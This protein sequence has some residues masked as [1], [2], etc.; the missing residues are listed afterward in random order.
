MN[1]A[2][3]MLLYALARTSV[4]LAVAAIVAF[5]LLR[6]LRCRSPAVHRAAWCMVLLTGW[7]FVRATVTIPWYE[8]PPLARQMFPSPASEVLEVAPS[9]DPV[10]SAIGSDPV[11]L[12]DLPVKIDE[13]RDIAGT[14]LSWP[15][16]LAAVWL[17][18]GV[19]IV[20]W[21]SIGYL[22]FVRQL[23]FGLPLTEEWQAEW[24]EAL[25]ECAVRHPVRLCVNDALGP[26]VCRVWGEDR[27]LAPLALWREL[28]SQE[29]R[30]ILRH[31]LAHVGRGDLVWSMAARCLALAH[32]FNPFCWWA[33]RNF[34]ECG[35]WA[36]DDAVY[37]RGPGDAVA[38][39]RVLLRIGQAD[40]RPPLGAAIGGRRLSTRIK[41]MLT[42]AIPEDST[43][44]QSVLIGSVGV[45][46]L[47]GAVE[48]RLGARVAGAVDQEVEATRGRLNV[49]HPVLERMAAAA[50]KTFEATR[51]S[52]DV[53]TEVMSNVYV[54]SRRWLEAERA[55]AETDAQELAALRAHRQRM[56]QL[57]LKVRA[58]YV[59]GSRGGEEP[60]F[61]ATKFYLAEADAWLESA[62]NRGHDQPPPLRKVPVSFGGPKGMDVRWDED[63]D[64]QFDAEPVVCPARHDFLEGGI[65]FL[66][67]GGFGGVKL[68][69][70]LEVMTASDQPRA[71]DISIAE[72]KKIADNQQMTKV[73]FLGD[74]ARVDEISDWDDVSN[75]DRLV[76]QTERRHQV[77]AA[78]HFTYP[79]GSR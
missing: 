38:Y 18:G 44:K 71:F 51:A 78:L 79:T 9:G 12:G 30:A 57:M 25:A 39:A 59:T 55:L 63:N 36:C 46:A 29:R 17:L 49:D 53:G 32:W 54:W 11:P 70:T 6:G 31:E 72:V 34:D 73:L 43:M 35:E 1:Q 13:P 65:Y 75:S 47:I 33:V 58:F 20:A 67:F 68:N 21:W 48:W 5:L 2:A 23:P 19:A 64:G 26:L 56:K 76:A 42:G 52:Y 40:P 69:A 50:A 61:Y 4:C 8:A 77:L 15:I 10:P 27:L 62:K 45:L 60:K 7:L 16:A 66:Q 24:R 41:R 14:A 74:D 37:R 28:S 22:R 3:T